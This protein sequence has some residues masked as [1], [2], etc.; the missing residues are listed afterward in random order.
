MQAEMILM[1]ILQNI[2][3]KLYIENDELMVI[4]GYELGKH[5]HMQNDLNVNEAVL[6]VD[7]I[8]IKKKL[9]VLKTEYV[10]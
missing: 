7:I 6:I 10:L 1:K 4:Y 2:M 3:E 8:K 9:N 5:D